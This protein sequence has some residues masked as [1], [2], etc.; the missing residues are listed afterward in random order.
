[1]YGG[2]FNNLQNGH[3]TALR[4]YT[5]IRMAYFCRTVSVE[6]ASHQQLPLS[7]HTRQQEKAPVQCF[8]SEADV[9]GEM[10]NRESN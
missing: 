10:E 5:H 7:A 6:L 2:K 9:S 8:Q 3:C 1:M 4:A